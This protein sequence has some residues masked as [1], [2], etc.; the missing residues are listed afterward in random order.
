MT[1][2]GH[3]DPTPGPSTLARVR[4][5]DRNVLSLGAVSFV[6]DLS[7]ELIYPIFPYF[8]TVVLGAP[9]AVL[10]LIEGVAEA[11]ASLSRYPFGRWSDTSAKRKPFVLFGYGLSALGKLLL[12]LAL[13]WPVALAGRFVDRTGKGMRTA[14]RD[15]LLAARVHDRD[16]GLAFGLHR[17]LDTLGAVLGPLLAL[18]L[19]HVGMSYRW[20]FAVAVIPGVL[21]VLVIVRYVRE[22]APRRPLAHIPACACHA[23]RPSAGCSPA[24]SSS[25]PATRPTPSSCSRPA[26]SVTTPAG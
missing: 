9:V 26:R 12:A 3:T 18:V 1:S 5:L 15:A 22:R 25:R 11:T 8:V 21:S 13:V 4:L 7:S 16:R 10:G 2:R 14:P 6:A 17:S 19:L 20:I 23:P 24:R